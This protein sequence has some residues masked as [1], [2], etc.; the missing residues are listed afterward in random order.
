M[1]H[2]DRKKKSSKK[3]NLP[4]TFMYSNMVHITQIKAIQ[5]SY[6]LISKLGE[7]SS[8]VVYKAISLRTSNIRA[9]KCISKAKQ[10]TVTSTLEL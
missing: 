7:G 1:P 4:V 10:P 3:E 2:V 8:G 5:E 9:I 6:T